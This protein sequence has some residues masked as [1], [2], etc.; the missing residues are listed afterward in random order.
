M[1]QAVRQ[2][3]L[4]YLAAHPLC[5]RCDGDAPRRVATVVMCSKVASE[6]A[7]WLDPKHAIALC[8]RHARD[9]GYRPRNVN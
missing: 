1:R 9:V 6:P 5:S 4:D 8:Q 7:I 3:R 2:F